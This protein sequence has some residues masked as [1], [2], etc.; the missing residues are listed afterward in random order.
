MLDNS[1][2]QT[3]LEYLIELPKA[4][5]YCLQLAMPRPFVD[6]IQL[7]VEQSMKKMVALLAVDY[8][9]VYL[10]LQVVAKAVVV[11]VVVEK[12]DADLVEDFDSLDILG[13]FHLQMGQSFYSY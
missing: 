7:L 1:E 5:N 9:A 12:L 4:V 6:L 8:E 2:A 10:K 11:V 3:K 13:S